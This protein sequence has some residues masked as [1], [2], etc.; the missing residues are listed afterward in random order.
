MII[1]ALIYQSRFNEFP[2]YIPIYTSETFAPVVVR[3]V[4]HMLIKD[5][6]GKWFESV[7]QYS[8]IDEI[9]ANSYGHREYDFIHRCQPSV[10]IPKLFGVSESEDLRSASNVLSLGG[11]WQVLGANA[12]AA[13]VPGM[14]TYLRNQYHDKQ[15][16]PILPSGDFLSDFYLSVGGITPELED[17][18]AA[19]WLHFIDQYLSM[20]DNWPMIPVLSP[21]HVAQNKVG[22]QSLWMVLPDS[23]KVFVYNFLPKITNGAI[24]LLDPYLYARLPGS[25]GSDLAYQ[26]YLSA[27]HKLV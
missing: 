20:Y 17:T 22:A 7:N 16:K 8:F 14:L 2:L 27:T 6:L 10:F 23:N 25:K 3:A 13:T 11:M 21:V 26:W 4:K 24:G 9:P 15:V 19:S 18:P 1:V 12:L 5:Y